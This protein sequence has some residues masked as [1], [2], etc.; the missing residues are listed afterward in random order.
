MRLSFTILALTALLGVSQAGAA[1]PGADK[2]SVAQLDGA[3]SVT[4]T[5]GKQSLV[6]PPFVVSGGRSQGQ[7]GAGQL[8]LSYE[9]GVTPAGAIS[10]SASGPNVSGR[11]SGNVT[12]WR[13]GAF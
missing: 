8:M 6:L 2:R 5:C 3:W 4:A 7:W 12:D 13:H 9:V 10:G 11:I 1:G